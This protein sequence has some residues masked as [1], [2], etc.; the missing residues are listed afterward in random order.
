MVLLVN[1][2]L[3]LLVDLVVVVAVVPE[4]SLAALDIITQVQHNKAIQ[5]VRQQLLVIIAEVAAEQ[6]Q[7]EA[8]PLL[9]LAEMAAQDILGHIL[10]L[11][12]LAVAAVAVI[13]QAALAAQVVAEMLEHLVQPVLQV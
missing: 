7:L 5:V 13:Q 10:V 2:I 12:T 8:M 3:A 4:L 11:H 1:L 9:L 6:E